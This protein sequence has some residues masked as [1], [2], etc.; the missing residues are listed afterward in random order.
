MMKRLLLLGILILTAYLGWRLRPVDST[1]T[2]SA[3][4]L[5]SSAAAP[6][7]RKLSVQARA[8]IEMDLP[9]TAPSGTV[10]AKADCEDERRLLFAQSV[11]QLVDQLQRGSWALRGECTPAV[12]GMDPAVCASFAADPQ[13]ARRRAEC[14]NFLTMAR[15]RLVD[16]LTRDWDHYDSMDLGVLVNKIVAHLTR[17]RSLKAEEVEEWR[18]MTEALIR[19]TPENPEAVKAHIMTYMNEATSDPFGAESPLWDWVDR[20]LELAPGDASLLELKIFGESRG[21]GALSRLRNLGRAY[22]NSGAVHYQTAAYYWRQKDRGATLEELRRA[23]QKEPENQRYQATF[24][25]A[26]DPKTAFD[27]KI[28][29]V[30]LGFRW[31]DF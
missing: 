10:T 15:A 30:S 17:L 5:E 22:P 12:M 31:D 20:G 18:Q 26:Q 27:E 16:A 25:K 19:R 11:D 9:I 6:D 28:F 4:P 23:L 13:D 7:P 8:P 21:E 1:A 29:M 24:Q 3:S 14:V 2:T